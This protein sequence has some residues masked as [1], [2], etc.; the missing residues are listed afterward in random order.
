MQ[1]TG[2]D[3]VFVPEET[4]ILAAR[5]LA[6]EPDNRVPTWLVNV[7]DM[8]YQEH[9]AGYPPGSYRQ[10]PDTVHRAFLRKTGGC[11]VDQYLATNPLTM[12]AHGYGDGTART[13][14]TGAEGVEMD[15]RVI[16]SPEA[17]VGH[18]ESVEF[19]RLEAAL[20]EASGED[21]GIDQIVARE[22]DMQAELG[23]GLLK[24]PYGEGFNNFPGLRY[25]QYGY[26]NYFT[27]F[28]MY[29]EVMERDFRLQGRLAALRNRAAVRAITTGNLPRV[30]RLDHDMADSGG[31]LVDTR[32]LNDLW[33]PHFAEAVRPYVEAGI[34]LVWHCDG[35]LMDMVPRLIA[36]GVGGFQGFQYEDGMDYE[37]ICRM[38]G[39]DGGPLMIWGGVSVTRTL[40]FGTPDDV[41]REMAW[42]VEHAPPVGFV[43]GSSSSVTPGVPWRNL[44]AFVEGLRHYREEG[45]AA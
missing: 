44:D 41:R 40:P 19:P 1:R 8:G 29:P 22:R 45:R 33:F 16:D 7:M 6:M 36:C 2:N 34:R 39:P 5:T 3:A 9:V 24:V 43:L 28:V 21:A 27:A 17:V 14:S 15:G 37:R 23:P 10:D 31:T 26:V 13:A 38:T 11:M 30:I 12:E 20:A 42:L 25:M 18:L 4:A 32:M 35:N